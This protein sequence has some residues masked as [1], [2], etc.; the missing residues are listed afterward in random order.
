MDLKTLYKNQCPFLVH[1]YGAFY[2]EGSVK[3]ALEYMELGSIGSILKKIEKR[4]D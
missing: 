3:V 1:F 2:D 4:K